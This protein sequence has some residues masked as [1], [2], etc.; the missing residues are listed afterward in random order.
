[1]VLSIGLAHRC[2]YAPFTLS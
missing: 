1:L 2:N